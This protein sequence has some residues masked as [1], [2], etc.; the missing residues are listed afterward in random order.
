MKYTLNT[1]FYLALKKHTFFLIFAIFDT[2]NTGR[3]ARASAWKTTLFPCFC[4]RA[5]YPPLNTS[6]PPGIV[7]SGEQI[8]ILK[9]SLWHLMADFAQFADFQWSIGQNWFFFFC[10]KVFYQNFTGFL[11][12]IE[13]NDVFKYTLSDSRPYTTKFFLKTVIFN[14]ARLHPPVTLWLL[15]GSYSWVKRYFQ[16]FSS[17]WPQWM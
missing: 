11:L 3:A 1:Y 14:I 17:E 2:P 13:G 16:L 10:Q 12:L 8:P 4:T 6:G 7:V 5:W 15:T 9:A